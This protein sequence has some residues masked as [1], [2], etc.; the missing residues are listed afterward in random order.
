MCVYCGML[1]YFTR[2]PT[3]PKAT[4]LEIKETWPIKYEVETRGDWL[5]KFL[6][7]WIRKILMGGHS[8]AS[9]IHVGRRPGFRCGIFVLPTQ[10][11]FYFWLPL[12]CDVFTT[13]G[14]VSLVARDRQNLK[15]TPMTSYFFLIYFCCAMTR[16]THPGSG[17]SYNTYFNPPKVPGK[18]DVSISESFNYVTIQ[19]W[20][21]YVYVMCDCYYIVEARG[22]ENVLPTRWML[23]YSWSLQKNGTGL[24]THVVVSGL[25]QSVSMWRCTALVLCCSCYPSM[26]THSCCD[27]PIR[28]LHTL[29]DGWW[30]VS[31]IRDPWKHEDISRPETKPIWVDDG[32]TREEGRFSFFMPS[33]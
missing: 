1:E 22:Q 16:W 24:S 21:Y 15:H 5:F 20:R 27:A 2:R 11:K 9:L 3:T 33:W 32:M 10:T 17:R 29:K 13:W 25:V 4:P 28:I 18:D 19:P 26:E 23:N 14:A 30:K 7:V 31:R 8:C 6:M 12:L